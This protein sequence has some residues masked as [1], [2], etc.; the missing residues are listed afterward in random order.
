MILLFPINVV[1]F[2]QKD[3]K[4]ILRRRKY[5]YISILLPLLL[6]SIYIISLQTSSSDIDVIICDLDSTSLTNEAI[7]T[8]QN[9]NIKLLKE[10]CTEI[11][12]E[13]VKNKNYLFGFLIPQGF[14]NDIDNLKQS[15]I[16][17]YYDNSEPATKALASWR[18]DS[19]LLP[20]KH[21][22]IGQV[23]Q[24]IKFKSDS[25][26]SKTEIALDIISFTN[27]PTRLEENIIEVDDELA[28]KVREQ[29]E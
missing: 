10:N 4:L 12:I 2:I 18:I 25:A 20:L 29:K 8:M 13:E 11:I 28:L 9:F 15:N 24:D 26:K 5:L 23:S 19:A 14:T 21:E 17:V 16:E 22:I 27:I 1:A 6:G 3:T 7:N